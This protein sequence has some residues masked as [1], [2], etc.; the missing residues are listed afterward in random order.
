MGT[1]KEIFIGKGGGL[2]REGNSLHQ[3]KKEKAKESQR[4]HAIV[5]ALREERAP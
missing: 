5:Q 1:N 2:G 3:H 4:E